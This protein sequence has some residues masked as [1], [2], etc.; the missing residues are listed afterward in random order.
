MGERIGQKMKSGELKNIVGIPTSERTKEQA[1]KLGIPLATLDTHPKLDVAIDGADAVDP[2]L[3]L[4]KGGGGAHFREKIV[5]AS[6]K[7]FVV[8]IDESKVCDFLGPSFPVPVE[9]VPFCHLHTARAIEAL[10]AL[11]GCKAELR[12]GSLSSNK[13]DG[14]KPAITDNANYIV[15]LHFKDPILDPAAAAKQ[16]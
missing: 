15:D 11:Q 5:E 1:E 2:F 3:N 8:I 13:K 14:K 9:I 4:V 6:S 12:Y 16:L 7:Q 10:P